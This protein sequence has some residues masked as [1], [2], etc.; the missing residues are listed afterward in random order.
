MVNDASSWNPWQL[1]GLG[2]PTTQPLWKPSPKLAKCTERGPASSLGLV[3][4]HQQLPNITRSHGSIYTQPMRGYG[5]EPFATPVKLVGSSWFHRFI[6][7]PRPP[8]T[9]GDHPIYQS[10][11]NKYYKLYHPMSHWSATTVAHQILAVN[12]LSAPVLAPVAAPLLRPDTS[13]LCDAKGLLGLAQ[14]FAEPRSSCA[15]HSARPTWSTPAEG[16]VSTWWC[17]RIGWL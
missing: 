6:M 3:E 1:G 17:W 14:H 5:V 16:M 8:S 9:Y 11:A 7:I 13:N 12:R 15:L 4:H 2:P 10:T